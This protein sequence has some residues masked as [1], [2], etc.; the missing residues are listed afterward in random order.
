MSNNKKWRNKKINLANYQTLKV[1]KQ[2]RSLSENWKIALT[3]LFLIAFPSFFVFL[4]VGRDGWIITSTRNLLNTWS[5]LL[6]IAIGMVLIQISVVVLLIFKFKVFKINAL[7]FLVPIAVA[8]N[9]FIVSSGTDNW[10]LRVLP[11]VGLAFLAIPLLLL[12]KHIEKKK[13]DKLEK[14][15]Q[16]EEKAKRSLLD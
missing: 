2:R 13:K 12:V 15:V 5:V 10:I 8:M 11:A 4:L 6:P 1:E 7:I 9:S 16:E 3:G 14:V